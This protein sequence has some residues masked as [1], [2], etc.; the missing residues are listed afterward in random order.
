[1]ILAAL[2]LLA[3][4]VAV[5]VPDPVL[6]AIAVV[7]SG[8][9]HAA[10]GDRTR[11]GVWRA[12]GAWQIHRGTWDDACRRLGIHPQNWPWATYAHNPQSA[13][14][15]AAEILRWFRERLSARGVFPSPERLYACWRHG[16]AGFCRHSYRVDRCPKLTRERAWRVAELAEKSLRK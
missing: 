9:N 1:M 2:T 12:R 14:V 4:A 7:E 13:R 10:R 11:A 16:L 3:A 15:V 5:T 6:D 8:T